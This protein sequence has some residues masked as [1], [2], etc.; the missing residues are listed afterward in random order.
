MPLYQTNLGVFYLL[1]AIGLISLVDTICKFY[2]DELHAVMLVWGY[3]V[4]ITF[5]VAGYFASRRQF[6]L[7][8]SG[9]PVLQIARSG[10]RS[11]NW[12]M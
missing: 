2:T 10:F 9:Q 8:Q 6:A 7:L 12:H 4:G 5:F 11:P 1:A 3:F